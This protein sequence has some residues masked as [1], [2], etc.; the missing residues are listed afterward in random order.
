MTAMFSIGTLAQRTG[1]TPGT[2]RT[3]EHRFGFPLAHRAASGHRRYTDEDVALVGE[4]LRA[5]DSGVPLGLAIETVRSRPQAPGTDSVYSALTHEF[6]H[7]RRHRLGRASLLVLSRAIED[8]ALAQAERAVVIATFQHGARYAGSRARWEELARTGAWSAVLADFSDGGLGSDPAAVPARCQ[9]P[10]D[11]P[12]LR[13]WTVVCVGPLFSAVL[14]AWQVPTDGG[15][16]PTYE[17]VA[18]SRRSVAVAAARVLTAAAR[19]AGATPPEPV[20]Q[21]LADEPA[22]DTRNGVADGLWLRAIA[23]MDARTA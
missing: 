14:S 2:L 16:R 23:R 4:V 9:L 12:L 20:D 5:R 8:E 19:S 1:L 3:W 7:L 21:V 11:S 13:E 6:A 17:A 15:D 18:S 10:A 22:D